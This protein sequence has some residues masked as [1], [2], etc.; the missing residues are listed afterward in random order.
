M[1]EYARSY[2]HEPT[3]NWILVVH[4][5]D[6]SDFYPFED[7]TQMWCCDRRSDVRQR[8]GE[9]VRRKEEGASLGASDVG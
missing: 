9:E 5:D 8:L 6:S 2:G 1:D 3:E 4:P 7:P